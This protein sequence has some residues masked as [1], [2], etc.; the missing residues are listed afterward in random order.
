M[1]E[2]NPYLVISKTL[3]MGN[4]IV[5]E[6]G[7][8]IFQLIWVFKMDYSFLDADLSANKKVGLI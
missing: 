8:D 6:F 7:V 4:T 5:Q 1:I 2:T 3:G